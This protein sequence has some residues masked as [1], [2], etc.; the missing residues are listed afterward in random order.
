[1]NWVFDNEEQAI[2][3]E[4]DCVPSLPFFEFCDYFLDK[5]KNNP[6]IGFIS[7]DNYLDKYDIGESDHIISR[8]FYMFGFATWR[9]RWQSCNFKIEVDEFLEKK[10]LDSY[11][12]NKQILKFWNNYYK[13]ISQFMKDTHCWD[14]AFAMNN[15]I[16]KSYGVSPKYNLVQNVGIYGAHSNGANDNSKKEINIKSSTYP[17]NNNIIIPIQPDE[18]YEMLIFK[19]TF[20][21]E[22]KILYRIKNKIKYILKRIIKF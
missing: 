5:Y 15:I 13:N 2:I 16:R 11:Y 18:N 1:M 6:Q 10:F 22:L 21:K 19:Q 17:F 3:L 7:G 12:A 14:Y 20:G 8:V 9:D 4:E